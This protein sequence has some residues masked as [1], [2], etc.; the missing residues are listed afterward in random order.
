MKPA[1]E[2]I[3]AALE[4]AKKATPG[5]WHTSSF[6]GVYDAPHMSH[7]RMISTNGENYADDQA[8]KDDL[9][10]ATMNP[11]FAQALLEGWLEF[12]DACG[13]S[14]VCAE[15]IQCVACYALASARSK[16]EK[17]GG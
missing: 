14:C 1:R 13:R 10:I 5:P 8:I 4:T 3:E 15:D 11:E 17:K 16:F 6:G 12:E 2:Q 9:Y 7:K